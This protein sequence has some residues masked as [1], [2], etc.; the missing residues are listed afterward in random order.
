MTKLKGYQEINELEEKN[1]IKIKE[2]PCL[3]F[4]FLYMRNQYF[5][6]IFN[7]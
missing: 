7:T 3:L 6:L 4:L 1:K 2:H 5:S